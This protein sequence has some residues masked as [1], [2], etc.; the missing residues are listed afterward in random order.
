[1]LKS[2]PPKVPSSFNRKSDSKYAEAEYKSPMPSKKKSSSIIDKSKKSVPINGKSPNLNNGG[3]KYDSAQPPKK[4]RKLAPQDRRQINPEPLNITSSGQA[5]GYVNYVNGVPIDE[6][7]ASS[8]KNRT[9][10][11]GTTPLGHS[12][13]PE[14]GRKTNKVHYLDEHADLRKSSSKITSPKIESGTMS[15]S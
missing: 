4:T 9:R 5:L 6:M 1:M 15:Q 8:S 13:L 11:K 14:I 10:S 7:H 12:R 2:S 3:G